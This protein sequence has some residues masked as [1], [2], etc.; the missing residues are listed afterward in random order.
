MVDLGTSLVVRQKTGGIQPFDRDRLLISV[1][2]AVGHRE[3]PI[4][5]ASA[6]TATIAAELVHNT[7]GA[8]VNLADITET[9]LQV[10]K[11]FDSAAA[12][13]YA[14]YHPFTS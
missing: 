1:Y 6:L 14:A 10:L 11:R 9:A 3:R 4:S 12:V 5:D 13:Q 7:A 2:R 8:A